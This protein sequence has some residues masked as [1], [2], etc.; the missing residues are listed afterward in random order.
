MKTINPDDEQLIME[1]S[2]MLGAVCGALSRP[3]VREGLITLLA[4]SPEG[5]FTFAACKQAAERL[6][7]LVKAA[8][9][10]RV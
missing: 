8:E 10:K 7:D 4:Q 2:F 9:I 3:D 6:N 5:D 1:M